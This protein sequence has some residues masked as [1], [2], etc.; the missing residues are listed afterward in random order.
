MLRARLEAREVWP[1][2]RD[3]VVI[4]VHQGRHPNRIGLGLIGMQDRRQLA[5]TDV[6]AHDDGHFVDEFARA[7]GDDGRAQDLVRS[8][9]HVDLHE[10]VVAPI[11]DGAIRR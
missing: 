10:T 6:G 8:V 2:A 9:L 3:R 4:H 11:G 1:S 5:H 7:R